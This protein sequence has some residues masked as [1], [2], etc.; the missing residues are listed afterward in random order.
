MTWVDRLAGRPKNRP[1]PLSQ[2]GTRMAIRRRR[3]VTRH[4]LLVSQ[5]FQADSSPRQPGKADL[6]RR[7]FTLIELLVVIAIIAVLIGL[8]LP[9]VQ[10]VRAAASRTT[11]QNKLKQLALAMHNAHDSLGGFPTG[12]TVLDSGPCPSKTRGNDGARAPWSVTVLPFLEQDALFHGFDFTSNFSTNGE[13]RGN[14]TNYGLQ[15]RPNPAF[16]CPSDP[17]SAGAPQTNYIACAG[18][19]DPASCPCK[20]SNNQQFILYANGVFFINSKVRLTDVV[21]G[22]SNTYLI[23]ETKYQVA[24]LWSGG[25]DKRGFWSAGA[26]LQTGW[27][28]YVNLAAAVEPINQ[29]LGRS[30]YTGSTPRQGEL[31]VGRTFG[32]FHPG[33]CNMAFA[34]G[35]VR[36][37]PN[38]TDLNVHRQLGTIA[39]GLPVGGLP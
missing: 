16:Q 11:C 17:R 27:R 34:D 29:P 12:L 28:Y 19:G 31:Y 3:G 15:T 30:D 26:D 10:K 18:G 37:M 7:G 38:A 5:P 9:A 35:G 32:S 21:D 13:W 2:A 20:A 39:D 14:A 24:D 6:R 22:S 1:L 23:G 4:E 25:V 8:L 33:G 36:F